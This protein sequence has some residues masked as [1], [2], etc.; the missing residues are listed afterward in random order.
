M[1][2][3]LRIA[4]AG[5]LFHV[6]VRGVDRR[7]IF[8]SATDYIAFLSLLDQAVVCYEWRCRFYCL[9]GNHFHLFVVTPKPTL[10]QGMQHLNGCY[11]QGFNH[12]HGR[13]GPLFEDRFGSLRIESDR[14]LLE[15]L[16]YLALNPVRAGLCAS[17]EDWRWSSFSA[18]VGLEPVPRFLDIDP[19]LGLFGANRRAAQQAFR[20]FVDEGR[21]L[22]RLRRS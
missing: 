1:A 11:A 8:Q 2:R 22:S 6:T 17:P 16:R 13:R 19:V 15:L 7:L 18:T 9:M 5:G 20:T 3:R 10:S 21:V 14:H 4:P 12:R